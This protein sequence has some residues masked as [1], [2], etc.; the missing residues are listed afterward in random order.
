H[1][2]DKMLEAI[3]QSRVEALPQL[4]TSLGPLAA[5][6]RKCLARVPDRRF[7]STD[8]ILKE[9]RPVRTARPEPTSHPVDRVIPTK[10]APAPRKKAP[11]IDIA[12][13]FMD[14]WK[15]IVPVVGIA[16]LAF[17]IYQFWRAGYVPV[18]HRKGMAKPVE[19]LS[20]WSQERNATLS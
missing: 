7:H 17:T 11:S 16:A 12:Q 19:V 20:D 6:I 2:R 9:L 10:S 8:E 14:Y 4:P 3:D 1:T 15:I 5:V 13:I 18:L